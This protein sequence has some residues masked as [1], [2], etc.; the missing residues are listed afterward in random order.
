MLQ[1]VTESLRKTFGLMPVPSRIIAGLL[2][3]AIV[4]ALG[5]LVRGNGEAE[6]EFLL[7]GRLMDER[8]LDAAEVAGDHGQELRLV[9]LRLAQEVVEHGAAELAAGTPNASSPAAAVTSATRPPRVR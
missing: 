2:I 1:N 5:F 4:L 7:G 8:D 3:V 6:T 9:H